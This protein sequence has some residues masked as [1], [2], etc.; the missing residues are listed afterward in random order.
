MVSAKW[1]TQK[2]LSYLARVE[3]RGID[4]IGIFNDLTTVVSK[5][6]NV[7]MRSVK[8][9]VYGEIFTGI[10]D[11]YVHSTQDLNNM[12]MNMI[13]LKGID[14]VKRIEIIED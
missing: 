14:S 11:V 7:N 13:K 4:R 9:D 10:I 8:F 6:L 3:I 12:I 2:L 5:E 1:E